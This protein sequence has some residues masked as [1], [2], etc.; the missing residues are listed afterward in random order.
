MALDGFTLVAQVVNFLVLVLLLRHLLYGRIIDAMDRREADIAARLEEAAGQRAEAAREAEGFRARSR[1]LEAQREA[2]LEKAA[3]EASAERR[4]LLDEARAEAARSQERWLESLR[5]ER[6]DL[7]G[8]FRGRLAGGVVAL[9]GQGLRQLADADL[10]AQVLKVFERR[11][12]ELDDAQREAL[13]AGARGQGGDGGG[14]VEVRTAFALRAESEQALAALLRERFGDGIA[15]RFATAPELV[16]GIEL[17]AQSHRVGW[18]LAAYL[19][20]LESEIFQA[21]D[22]RDGGDVRAG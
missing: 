14:E 8:E 6:A 18:N 15:V 3:E 17:Q 7:A 11:L 13:V 2:L 4:R 12:G 21:L 10:E 22:A 20:G 19:E 9:A 1:E 5:R 16:C